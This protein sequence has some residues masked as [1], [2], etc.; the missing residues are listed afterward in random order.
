[1]TDNVSK[2]KRSWIMSRIKGKDTKPEMEVRRALFKKG[3]RYRV[4]NRL[5]GRPDIIF[6]KKRI[7]IFVHGCFWHQ[8]DCKHGRRP[9]S[10]THFWNRKLD[11]NV[12]RDG[13]VQNALA[14]SGWRVIVIWE[15]DIKSAKAQTMEALERALSEE[16]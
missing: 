12:E 15:C 5:S 10:N 6:P 14:K 11:R 7:A 9:K 16:R 4:R 1:M 13:K 3:Y 2:A 8:H